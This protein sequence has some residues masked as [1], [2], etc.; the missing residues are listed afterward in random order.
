MQQRNTA[1]RR[2]GQPRR[3][4][5]AT[6]QQGRQIRIVVFLPQPFDDVYAR[7]VVPQPVITDDQG[8]TLRQRKHAL[9]QGIAAG[10]RDDAATPAFK[11]HRQARQVLRVVVHQQHQL[12]AQVRVG[13]RPGVQGRAG[14]KRGQAGPGGIGD[15]HRD[16]E[17]SSATLFRT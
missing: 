14:L 3:I 17:D 8:G 15:R 2:L 9:E 11:Q 6:D 10:G 12:S 1:G 13:R 4:G 16:G 5:I 7:F